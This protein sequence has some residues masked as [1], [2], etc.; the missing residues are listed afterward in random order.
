MSLS[1]RELSANTVIHHC[2]RVLIAMVGVVIFCRFIDPNHFINPIFLGVLASALAETDDNFSSRLSALA[3]TLVCF[4]LT[5]FSVEILFN[6][7]LIFALGFMLATF[8]FTLL[9]AISS[10]YATIAFASLLISVYTMIGASASINWWTQPFYLLAGATWYGLVS[11]A[12]VAIFPTQPVQQRFIQLFHSL[13]DYLEHKSS[14]FHPSTYQSEETLRLRDANANAKVVDSLNLT[15]FTILNHIRGKRLHHTSL[16]YL[17]MY[18]LAQDIHE[19]ANSSH[20]RYDALTKAFF[21]SDIMFRIQHLLRLQATTCRKTAD[22]LFTQTSLTKSHEN[23]EAHQE[24]YQSLGY[25]KEKNTPD[26]QVFLPQ[27]EYLA[28]NLATIEQELSNVQDP[29]K[30]SDLVEDDNFDPHAHTLRE[31]WHRFCNKI[32]PKSLL[33]RHAVRLSLALALGYGLLNWFEF[34]NGYWILLTILFVCQ[35]NYSATRNRLV[36]RIFGTLIGLICGIP[37][38]TLFPDPLGQQA[39]M[40][41]FGVLFFAFRAA[42]YTVATTC[43]TLLVL[44]SFNQQGSGFDV[45]LPRLFDTLIGCLISVF[46]V[47]FILPDWQAHRLRSIMLEAILA[48]KDYLALIISQ[49]HSGKKDDVFY[50]NTR[51]KAHKNDAQL[52]SA[53][54]NMLAEP[55]RYQL[56]IEESFRFLCLNHSILNYVSALGANRIQITD[57]EIGQFVTQTHQDIHQRLEYMIEV[58]SGNSDVKAP[59]SYTSSDEQLAFWRKTTHSEA[60]MVLQQ[61]NLIQCIMPEMQNLTEQIAT[62]ALQKKRI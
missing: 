7:P 35:P 43:I 32:S 16:Q 51:R 57:D 48:N 19:R 31:K 45:M 27:L 28:N 62:I 15:K 41:L 47:R 23:T 29:L 53:I 14:L 10:R 13:G 8:S 37:L 5:T 42:K 24:L 9:G 20:C 30:P 26:T 38:L 39:L 49:Y 59:D 61:L 6:T 22:T 4:T 50:R 52:S 11:L 18:H 21:H 36:Q 25:L 12:W 17:K 58:L 3:L 55:G 33:F 40:I 2:I 46:A 54:T 1:F 44:I 56:A 34:Q 60:Q